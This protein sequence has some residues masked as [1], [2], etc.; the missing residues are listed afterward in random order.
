M[1]HY[2]LSCRFICECDIVASFHEYLCIFRLDYI[3]AS[4]QM[5]W[6]HRARIKYPLVRTLVVLPQGSTEGMSITE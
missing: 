3:I 1:R 4:F 6:I 5:L 2:S